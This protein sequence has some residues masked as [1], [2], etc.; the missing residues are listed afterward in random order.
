MSY[1]NLFLVFNAGVLPFWLLLIVL[2]RSR[3]TVA[4]V[5]SS[6]APLLLGVAY[7][8]F[9]ATA[10]AAGTDGGF[11]SLQGVMTAF[12]V[13]VAML[14]AWIHY[15]VFDLFVG[16]WEVRDAQRHGISQWVMVLVLLFTLMF[17]PAGLLLYLL[18][19]GL[20]KGQWSIAEG[21]HA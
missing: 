2:P 5:H 17:G 19:R 9:L 21:N 4:L 20:T 18:I 7:V 8:V 13:P 1:D 14:G 11:G 15:L 16:A 10:L 3:I 12:S 6:L